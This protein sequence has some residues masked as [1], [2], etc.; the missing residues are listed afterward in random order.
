M[1]RRL[2]EAM[3]EYI[4]Q[5]KRVRARMFFYDL[6][7]PD[8]EGSNKP[9]MLTF[10]QHKDKLVGRFF[11]EEENDLQRNDAYRS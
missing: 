1:L 8:I 7:L 2:F 11:Q 9:G 10:P 6:I 3:A 5:R 4:K